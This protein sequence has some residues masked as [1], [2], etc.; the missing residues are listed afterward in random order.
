MYDTIYYGKPP[1][2]S[3]EIR[4]IF[5]FNREVMKK[6]VKIYGKNVENLLDIG[7]GRCMA[8]ESYFQAGVHNVV[9]V[10]PSLYSLEDCKN[11]KNKHLTLY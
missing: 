8:V 2:K 10:E 9:G 11:L 1:K 7:V 6:Y 3:K 4:E 5:K